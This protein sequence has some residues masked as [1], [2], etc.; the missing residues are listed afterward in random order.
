ML[1]ACTAFETW[2]IQD[3]WKFGDELLLMPKLVEPL[4]ESKSD[5]AICAGIAERLGIGDAY[6]EGRDERQWVDHILDIYRDRFPDL[7]DLDTFAASNVGVHAERCARARR[8]VRGLPRGSG[9][10]SA[11]H[12]VG[13][14]RDLLG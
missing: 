5:Y 10:P 8:R 12:A 11:R 3:G 13:Q 7:P 4:G 9:R 6:T 14:G 2:G 1:P